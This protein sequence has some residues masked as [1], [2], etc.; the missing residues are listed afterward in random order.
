MNAF[1]SEDELKVL[2]GRSFKS[3][4]AAWLRSEGIPFRLSATGHPVVLWSSI[5]SNNKQPS[6]AQG[7]RPR[8]LE[9]A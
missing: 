1:L 6:P 7:W 8:V 2:T 5:D 3:K 4:Q 9:R